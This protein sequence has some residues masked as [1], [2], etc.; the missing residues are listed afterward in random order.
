MKC[1]SISSTLRRAQ[2]LHKSLPLTLTLTNSCT[3]SS[4]VCTPGTLVYSVLSAS[5]VW[6]RTLKTVHEGGTQARNHAGGHYHPSDFGGRPLSSRQVALR[7]QQRHFARARHDI[8]FTANTWFRE[9]EREQRQAVPRKD[10]ATE[11][12]HVCTIATRTPR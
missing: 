5:S 10:G 1:R 12:E 6:K 11:T 8:L 2:R 9:Q 3:A 4:A 7:D